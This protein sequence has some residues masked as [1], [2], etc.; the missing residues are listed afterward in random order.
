MVAVLRFQ[1]GEW[2]K[3]P[4]YCIAGGMDTLPKAFLKKNSHGWNDGVE[5]SKQI[6]FGIRVEKVLQKIEFEGT[7]VIIDGTNV[8]SGTS[9]KYTGDAVI[10]AVPLRVLRQIDVPLSLQKQKAIAGI[11]DEAATRILLQC[12][13]RFWQKEVCRLKHTL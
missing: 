4:L 9:E 12:K 6:K 11:N 2:W 10:L 5:L 3:D 7:K 1:F 8:A 13:T